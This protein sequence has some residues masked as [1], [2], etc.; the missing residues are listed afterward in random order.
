MPAFNIRLCAPTSTSMQITVAIKFSTERGIV[1]QFN[2]GGSDLRGFDVS[3]ISR[4][5]Y[6]D[7]R[8]FVGGYYYMRIESVR[9]RSTKTNYED[10]IYALF[11]LDQII[12]GDN[13]R[14]NN[15]KV[16]KFEILAVKHLFDRKI[17]PTETAAK[18]DNYIYDTFAT[19]AHHK[20]QITLNFTCSA[21]D[22][23]SNFL[24]LFMHPR[25]RGT[26]FRKDNDCSNLLKSKIFQVF[27]N[28]NTLNIVTGYNH[29]SISMIALLSLLE[30]G[31]LD[32]ITVIAGS[33][34]KENN[35][36]YSLWH[37][38]SKRLE[39]QYLAKNYK[40]N[41]VKGD[42]YRNEYLFVINKN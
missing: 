31:S 25:S 36:I 22:A 1:L 11:Y 16:S 5:G 37:L 34:S 33:D 28:L 40:I 14:V 19:F 29:Y 30:L 27:P 38:H 8:V 21:E 24:D 39:K 9:V 10:I 15:L 35:W 26:D 2:N 42:D 12:N 41:C 17:K 20:T 3:W 6:E 7:E 4:Y 32:K 18:F 23:N 13:V